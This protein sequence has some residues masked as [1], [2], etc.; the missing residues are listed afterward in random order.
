M[1]S[2][3]YFGVSLEDILWLL[4]LVMMTDCIVIAVPTG[5]KPYY[6]EAIPSRGT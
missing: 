3:A 5:E 2:N 1:N 4:P 6:A